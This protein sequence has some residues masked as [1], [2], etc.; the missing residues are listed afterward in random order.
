ML[1][2]F[3]YFSQSELEI[4]VGLLKKLRQNNKM[5]TSDKVEN[6]E[7]FDLDEVLESEVKFGKYQVKQFLLIAFPIFLNGI[8]SNAYIFTAGTL[9]YR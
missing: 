6:Q 1:N 3:V 5:S 8:F 7:Y 2:R 4:L 9:N